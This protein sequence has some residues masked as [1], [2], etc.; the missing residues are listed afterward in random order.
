MT[1]LLQQFKDYIR[2]EQLCA[3]T[4]KLLLAVSG[5]L[6]SCV[7][8][9]LTIAAGYHA[10]I[11][12]CNFGLRGAE[13]ERDEA[14]VRELPAEYGL[15]FHY[16][17]FETASYSVHHKVGIQEAARELRYTWFN[18]L[19]EHTGLGRLATAHHADDN[20]ETVLMNIFKGT[21]MAGLRGIL[22]LSGKIM[23]PMLFAAKE[24]L[25]AYAKHHGL[26]Y[27]TDSSNLSDK[28][29]RNFFR[30][31]IIPI[32]DQVYPGSIDNLKQN[33]RRFRE[34]EILYREAV[35]RK[36]KKLVIEK[37]GEWH[38]PVEKL[39]HAKPLRTLLFELFTPFGFNPA[40][41]PEIIKLMDSG[42]GK[43]I[44]SAT[45]RLL[46]NRNWFIISPV[47]VS[48]LSLIS[49]EE[50]MGSIV[51]PGG[52]IMIRAME[53]DSTFKPDTDPNIACI[54][55]REVSFPLIIRKWRP[56]DYFYPLGMKKKKKLARFLIDQKLSLAQKERVWVVESDKK[57]IWTVGLRIDDRY[58][59]TPTTRRILR[60]S[61]D[62]TFSGV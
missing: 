33:L 51:F 17:R 27:M 49:V 30:L 29:S 28:Y 57:I 50:G 40:Q 26:S 46:K 32:V 41:L 3:P 18:Q 35:E 24:E 9:H 8:L 25:E 47:M 38:I 37:E 21:G 55:G 11:A 2:T 54:D 7:L 20:A 4:D 44:S 60:I 10:E 19:L 45:H 36:L 39:R 53:I 34:A 23:R 13:S 61:F 16:R 6:D 52:E 15:P 1:E 22:P 31:N 43:H 58:K 5:G 48:N 42:S 14:F 59:L 56:G 12:H 62:P